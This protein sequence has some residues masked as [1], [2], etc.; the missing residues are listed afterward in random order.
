MLGLL[1]D[2]QIKCA[3][4]RGPKIIILKVEHSKEDYEKFLKELDFN[5]DGGYGCQ[6]L[7]GTVWFKDSTWAGRGEYDGSE[8]WEYYRLP[9]IPKELLTK[10]NPDC[11][12]KNCGCEKE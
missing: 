5:Y 10:N 7:F 12:C 3:T 2:K 4:I 1:E 6:E 8:W 9:N 11:K